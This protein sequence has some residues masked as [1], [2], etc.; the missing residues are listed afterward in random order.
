[1]SRLA[2]NTA[3]YNRNMFRGDYCAV[4]R[5]K[6]YNDAANLVLRGIVPPEGSLLKAKSMEDMRMMYSMLLDAINLNDRVRKKGPNMTENVKEYM[7]RMIGD[8][9]HYRRNV[10]PVVIKGFGPSVPNYEELTK[11][12][13]NMIELNAIRIEGLLSGMEF[14]LD[15][16]NR[17]TLV[18]HHED[19]VPHF[20]YADKLNYPIRKFHQHWMQELLLPVW[21]GDTDVDENN[22]LFID[23]T[24]DVVFIEPDATCTVVT[25]AWHCK[26]FYPFVLG[27]EGKRNIAGFADESTLEVKY[28]TNTRRS[29][30]VMA[31]A[32]EMLAKL[33]ATPSDLKY[34]VKDITE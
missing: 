6:I 27:A 28:H 19:S 20:W 23:R 1:M 16:E 15:S 11:V 31:L 5:D 34:F 22:S 24:F 29:E 3:Q 32:K 17:P 30:A 18:H 10:I 2:Q 12:G 21:Q 14:Q 13:T 9:P 26:N 7:D 4:D 25:D 8:A 33:A